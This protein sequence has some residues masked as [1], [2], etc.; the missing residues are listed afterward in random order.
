MDTISAQ[1]QTELLNI[2]QLCFHRPEVESK[3]SESKG[4]KR[5]VKGEFLDKVTPFCVSYLEQRNFDIDKVSQFFN[6]P[7]NTITFAQLSKDFKLMHSF[8]YIP[9]DV[10]S[11][12]EPVP[13][14]VYLC[15]MFMAVLNRIVSPPPN[16]TTA[17]ESQENIK[18]ISIAIAD[19]FLSINVFV[20]YHVAKQELVNS[21]QNTKKNQGPQ[22]TIITRII[23]KLGPSI[24][25]KSKLEP[26]KLACH[27]CHNQ[28]LRLIEYVELKRTSNENYFDWA[29]LDKFFDRKD[30]S[31]IT[32]LGN[33]R[34]NDKVTCWESPD[35]IH[36]SAVTIPLMSQNESVVTSSKF[37]VQIG[38]VGQTVY[39]IDLLIVEERDVGLSTMTW[40]Q[41]LDYLKKSFNV[42][43]DTIDNF[44]IVEPS[45]TQFGLLNIK[46]QNE[47]PKYIVIK[48]LGFGMYRSFYSSPKTLK[49]PNDE[50][51]QTTDEQLPEDSGKKIRF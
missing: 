34:D 30:F 37:M 9:N 26:V 5:D 1:F 7:Y 17:T 2:I 47:V 10:K 16:D 45:L 20:L 50:K 27:Q 42:T 35:P 51:A 13:Y 43:G 41:R 29:Q 36:F 28:L 39:I 6:V 8:E 48:T 25:Q 21:P 12:T 24:C 38:T 23:D 22:Y 32:T 44:K 11:T 46:I 14:S 18:S 33:I 19:L 40:L 15:R 49:R 3:E 31:A 4:Q